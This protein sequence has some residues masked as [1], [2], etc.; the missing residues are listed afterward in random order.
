MLDGFHLRKAIFRAAG[1]DEKN[2]EALFEA[3]SGGRWTQMNRLLI[4]LRE[5]AE[6]D[7]RKE[8]ILKSQD[9]LFEPLG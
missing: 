3:I 1:A 2:R 9:G 4:A 8:A 5:E 7:S 6:S